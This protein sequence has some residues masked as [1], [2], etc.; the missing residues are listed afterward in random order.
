MNL[1][2]VFV[3]SASFDRKIHKDRKGTMT[4]V[5]LLCEYV[6]INLKSIQIY[7]KQADICI[8]VSSCFQEL[9]P[10]SK[11]SNT[12]NVYRHSAT[13]SD[14]FFFFFFREFFKQMQ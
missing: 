10:H 6:F 13:F 11:G 2:I 5:S 12:I 8:Y 9:N 14:L 7:W 3:L 1:L 4:L